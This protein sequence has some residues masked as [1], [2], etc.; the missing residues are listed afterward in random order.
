MKYQISKIEVGVGKA[1]IE[2]L[3][4]DG[5]GLFVTLPLDKKLTENEVKKGI[6]S[7]VSALLVST[8]NA[9]VIHKLMRE[10]TTIEVLE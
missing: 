3:G 9:E 1:S 10:M 6:A 8:E 5:G 2:L 4:E 7:C